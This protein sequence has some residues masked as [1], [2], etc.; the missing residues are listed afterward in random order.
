VILAIL[1]LVL[2]LGTVAAFMVLLSRPIPI[3]IPP[4]AYLTAL[5]VAMVLAIVAV[6]RS[7]G[8]SRRWLAFTA[9]GVSVVLLGFGSYFNF[10]V[11]RVPAARSAFV[12]G[13]PAP[14]FTLPDS[15]G[16]PV[17]LADFRGQ[18]PVVLVFYR[19]YW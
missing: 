11:A 17:R 3:P 1:A 8:R 5:A 13:Q 15:A 18:K 10:V 19:G 7:R 16:R 12:V 14:D 2:S 6:M 4:A 9:L